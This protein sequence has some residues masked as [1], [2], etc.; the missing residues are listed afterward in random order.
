MSR[1]M[2][3][4]ADFARCGALVLALAL[5]ACGTDAAPGGDASVDADATVDAEANDAVN[6]DANADT[7]ADAEADAVAA[8]LT[9]LAALCAG[10]AAATCAPLDGCCQTAPSRYADAAS[11]RAARVAGCLDLAKQELALIAEGKASFDSARAGACL[12]H[13]A[14]AAAACAVTDGPVVADVCAG[15]VRADAGVGSACAADADGLRCGD[16]AAPGLCFP[17]P[18][19]VACK[20]RAAQGQACAE[21][22]CFGTSAGQPMLCMPGTGGALVCDLPRGLGGACTAAVHCEAA[23][24]CVAGSCQPRLQT[25]AS[26]AKPWDCAPGLHCDALANVCAAAVQVGG[27]CYTDG[28]CAAG[29]RCGGVSVGQVCMF[30]DADEG[31]DAAG[32]P[33]L[34]QPCAGPCQKGLRCTSGPLAGACQPAACLAL[35]P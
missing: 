12:Q 4:P 8:P 17:T 19:G 6:A 29:L 33:G 32:A 2:A 34:G 21:T 23:H 7:E 1:P 16:D 14:A 26:C 28:T 30:G 15:V 9:D 20:A 3:R 35:A 25:G 22:P 27:A 11:C 31:T 13:Y 10:I 18:T 5:A 24:R